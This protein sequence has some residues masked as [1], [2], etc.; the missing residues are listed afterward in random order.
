MSTW[1]QPEFQVTGSP[2]QPPQP[3]WAPLALGFRPFF[4]AGGWSAVL[5]MLLFLVGYMSGLWQSNYYDFSLW[6]AH[7]MLFGFTMAVIAGFLLTAVRNWTGLDTPTGK[8]LGWL[9]ALWLAPRLLSA[10]PLIP[11]ALLAILDILFLPVLAVVLGRVLYK[12]GL[13]KN[14]IVPALLLLMCGAN[15]AIHL[16][17]LGLVDDIAR[18]AIRLMLNLVMVL[19]VLLS[20]RVV[21]FFIGG[22]LGARPETVPMVERFAIASV[23]VFAVAELF[24]SDTWIAALVALAAAI[25]HTFRLRSWYQPGLWTQPML[26]VLYLGY[27]WL[28]VGFFLHALADLSLIDRLQAVHAFT[29]G[30]IGTFTIGMMARVSLGHSGRRIE[31]LPWM[32]AAFALVFAAT[33]FRVIMPLLLPDFSDWF[34]IAAASCWVLAFAIFGLRYS[35]ILMRPRSDGRP[36]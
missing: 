23:F 26:W 6:H 15:I 24:L 16:E 28:V 35:A 3:R 19:V 20:G 7:E 1:H 32:T 25:L 18:P 14:Y 2:D 11:P 4:L 36:G 21:P 27:S 34:I 10:M 22:A 13:T 33:F 8:A 5:L 29:V 12:A 31:A 9:A 17:I 30:A